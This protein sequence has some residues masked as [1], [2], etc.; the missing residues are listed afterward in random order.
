MLSVSQALVAI[1]VSS[2][3]IYATRILPFVVFSSGN[4][5]KIVRFVEKYSPSLIMAVLVVYCFKDV[6]FESAGSVVPF[7][8]GVVST[9]VLQLTLKNTMVSIFSSTALYMILSRLM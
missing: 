2:A 9:A 6:H 1:F 3:I 4:P 7:A 5:P 8:A